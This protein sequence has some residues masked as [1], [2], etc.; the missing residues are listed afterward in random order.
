MILQVRRTICN[1]MIILSC[2]L[3]PGCWDNIDVGELA[4]V[5]GVGLDETEDGKIDLTVQIVNP[6]AL[7]AGPKASGRGQQPYYN[8]HGLGDTVATAFDDVQRQIPRR[9]YF[10]HCSVVI[11]GNE[12]A[13]HGLGPA[14]DY[15]HRHPEFQQYQLVYISQTT[16]DSVMK[17]SASIERI[18][19][20]G[21]RD[22]V[23]QRGN[24]AYSMESTEVQV[25]NELLNPSQSPVISMINLSSQG[26]PNLVGVAIL[27]KDQLKR[28]LDEHETEGLAWFL[29][30]IQHAIVSVPCATESSFGRQ[31][32]SLFNI[33]SAHSQVNVLPMRSGSP[34]F[35]VRVRGD[36]EITNL[37]PRLQLTDDTA[38]S[39]SSDMDH[40]VE[41]LMRKTLASLQNDQ[42]DAVHFGTILYEQNPKEWRQIESQW[43]K[44][45]SQCQV[46]FDIKFNILRSGRTGNPTNDKEPFESQIPLRGRLP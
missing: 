11:F 19:S 37:C 18:N 23:S 46:R 40:Q 8:I 41:N 44:A 35:L 1:L 39:L 6:S 22:L 28:T 2:L 12:F 45:F 30:H 31:Q 26:N 5:S 43:P 24:T 16:A 25:G 7:T 15:F 33:L 13:R 21:I 38:K 32:Q 9:V 10:Q 14:L 20:H 29:G 17:S 4:M 42:I 36:A 3:L 34:Q 27:R